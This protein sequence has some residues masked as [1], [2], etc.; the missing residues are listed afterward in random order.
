MDSVPGRRLALI[1]EDSKFA[2]VMIEGV[3]RES[4]FETERVDTA[5]KAIEIL[6]EVDPDLAVIDID[7][8]RGP[9]GF[10]VVRY[11]QEWLPW[12]AILIITSFRSPRL[13]DPD[14]PPLAG[15]PYLVKADLDSTE[16]VTLGI[17][18][19][20][21]RTGSLPSTVES[22]PSITPG[23]ADVLR[24]I[25]R[26]LSNELIAKQLSITPRAAQHATRRLYRSL[27]LDPG[28]GTNSRVLAT[29]LYNEGQ[30]QVRRVAARPG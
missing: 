25:A 20:M 3:V 18:R 22:Q 26:G 17:K 24:L 30:V 4:G 29:H 5:R 19:A 16:Q 28:D 12:T 7:L 10:E 2:G 14:V 23:Q 15:I 8:G 9:S 6:R 27:G 1:V 21:E 13:V 11:I